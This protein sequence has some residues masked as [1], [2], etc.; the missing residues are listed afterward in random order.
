MT[1]AKRRPR[2]IIGYVIGFVQ[3][4][5][6]NEPQSQAEPAVKVAFTGLPFQDQDCLFNL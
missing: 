6:L 2:A 1:V 3:A 5:G 4:K